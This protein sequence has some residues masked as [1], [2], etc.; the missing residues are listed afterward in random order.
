MNADRKLLWAVVPILLATTM[1][2]AWAVADMREK[3]EVERITGNMKTVC[4]GRFLIDMPTEAQIELVQP[5]ISGFNIGF[6]DESLEEF[7]A[8]LAERERHIQAHPNKPDAGP[9]LESVREIKTHKGV[10]G[11]V[12]VHSRQITE[13]TRARGMEIERYR[14][15]SV[16]VEALVHGK[17][18][19]FDISNDN[20]LPDRAD[21]I[22]HLVNQLDPN[23]KNQVPAAPGYCIDHAYFNNPPDADA[24]ERIMM[25]AKLPSHPDIAFMLILAAGTKPDEK[26]LLERDRSAESRLSLAERMRMTKLRAGTRMIGGIAGDEVIRTIVDEDKARGFDAWWEVNG[27]EEDVFLPHLVFKMDTGKGQEGPVPSSLSDGVALRVWDKISSSIRIRPTSATSST[28]TQA[29]LT[30]A[31]SP[32]RAPTP[33]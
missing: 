9:N 5:R 16:A 24:G 13:G 25:L 22:V 6:F 32:D 11:K 28:V 33:H 7:Q 1:I 30:P 8:R 29:R 15:E 12:F 10:N 31:G 21:R 18:I 4:V 19:S 26:G 2:G 27:K 20:Y 3:R 23:P 17:G 14:Y